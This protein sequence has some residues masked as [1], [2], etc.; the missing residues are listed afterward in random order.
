MIR[1]LIAED[2]ASVRS[3][4]RVCVELN[5]SCKVCG[6]ADNGEDAVV[7]AGQLKPDVVL[8]DYA[9]PVM[10]GLEAARLISS[11]LP[12][13]VLILFTIFASRQLIA[14][15]HQAGVRQVISKD[16]GSIHALMR[17]IDMISGKAA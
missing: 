12:Q 6:K 3:A 7:F 11:S 10:N 16:G 1:I 15:A 14:L 9:M 2:N 17:A 4:L 5:P 13:C 8:L